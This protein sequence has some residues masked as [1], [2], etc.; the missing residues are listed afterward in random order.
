[1]MN[2]LAPSC[3]DYLR[4]PLWERQL[5]AG[6]FKFRLIVSREQARYA[7]LAVNHLV[8]WVRPKLVMQR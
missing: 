8:V 5:A 4:P 2:R 7:T 1:M 6:K 3:H